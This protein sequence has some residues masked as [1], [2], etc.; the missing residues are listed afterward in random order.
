MSGKTQQLSQ[1]PEAGIIWIVNLTLSMKKILSKTNL[2]HNSRLQNLGF[3]TTAFYQLIGRN[4]A[5]NVASST[6]QEL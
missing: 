6:H 3:L 5:L 2:C 1:L 4:F